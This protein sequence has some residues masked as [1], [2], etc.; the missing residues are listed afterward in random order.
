M[1]MGLKGGR[2]KLESLKE[3]SLCFLSIVS[4]FGSLGQAEEK[5]YR[6]FAAEKAYARAIELAPDH[7]VFQRRYYSFQRM[8][9]D[10]DKGNRLREID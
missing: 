7:T 1:K 9:E 6:F 5:R 4:S 2:A 8:L 10:N 3:S